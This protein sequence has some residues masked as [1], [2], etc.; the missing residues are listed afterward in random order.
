LV[1]LQISEY[2][3]SRD[4]FP[5]ALTI[6]FN[7]SIY[8]LNTT[9]GV[10]QGLGS[11]VDIGST[12]NAIRNQGSTV[13]IAISGIPAMDSRAVLYSNIKGS[14]VTVARAFYQPGSNQLISDLDLPVAT[15][16]IVGRF[17]G[18][19]STYTIQ[20]DVSHENQSST[21]TVVF[22]CNPLTNLFKNLVKGVRTN[23]V[24]L[25]FL[26]NDVD[27]GFDAVPNL[28]SKEFYFGKPR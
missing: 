10:Y 17:A 14:K 13:S 18:Y 16:G 9:D 25:R 22:E 24:D 26:T 12:K 1:K 28:S 8:D 5:T 19:V 27:A 3:T 20:D 23:P 15:G 2:R 7:D 4:A 6:L 11:L 21:V